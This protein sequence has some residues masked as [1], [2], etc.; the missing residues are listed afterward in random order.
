MRLLFAALAASALATP[1]SATIYTFTDLNIPGIPYGINDA[2]QIVGGSFIYDLATGATATFSVPGAT[3]GTFASDINNL[4]Q[5]VGSFYQLN[6]ISP[7]FYVRNPDGTFTTFAGVYQGAATGINDSGQ[8]VGYSTISHTESG[9][10]SDPT[11]GVYTTL[12]DG[13]TGFVNNSTTAESI[14]DAGQVV[15]YSVGRGFTYDPV[16]ATFTNFTYPGAIATYAMG[17][18]NSG[19]IAGFYTYSLNSPSPPFSATTSFV[20]DQA[21]GTFTSL[22]DPA[23][24]ETFAEAINDAGDIVGYYTDANMTS[25]PFLAIPQVTTVPEPASIALLGAGLIGLVITR[26]QRS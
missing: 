22:S 10:L 5:V 3:G 15:G 11:S 21:S 24:V 23:G 6:A 12:I 7:N 13:K 16:S 19:Q 9:F 1:A 25:Q 4:G 8:V 17:I 2:G 14:N 18:N 26:R 20:L